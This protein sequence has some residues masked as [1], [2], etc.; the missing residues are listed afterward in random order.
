MTSMLENTSAKLREEIMEHSGQDVNACIQCG[1]CTAGC[2]MVS[3]MDLLPREI[4]LLLQNGAGEKVTNSKTPWVCASCFTCSARCPREI[5]ICRVMESVRVRL[6][7]PR[8]A[9]G[10]NPQDLP[11]DLLQ[12]LPQQALVSAFRKFAR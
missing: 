5:D 10:L 4:M 1:R 2:P 3:A 12:T 8:G 7:R 6:L 11:R 9:I